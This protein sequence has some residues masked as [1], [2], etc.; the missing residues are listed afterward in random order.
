MV[1]SK[2]YESSANLEH[3]ASAGAV[4]AITQSAF[5]NALT[6]LYIQK[7]TEKQPT[8]FAMNEMLE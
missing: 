7:G 1:Q 2:H 5:L 8:F 4:D 6:G 3:M